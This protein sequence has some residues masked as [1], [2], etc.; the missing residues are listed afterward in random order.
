MTAFGW[1]DWLFAAVITAR[2][3]AGDD[4]AEESSTKWLE[5]STNRLI[6]YSKGAY[7]SDLGPKD[8]LLARRAFGLYN[9]RLVQ[10]KQRVDPL[11]V[12][13][14]A[15]F[16]T[17]TSTCGSDPRVQSRGVVDIICS[18]RCSGK[19]RLA[20]IAA[21]TLKRMLL[22]GSSNNFGGN[23]SVVISSISGGTKRLYAKESSHHNTP[24]DGK[25]LIT[26][27][28][29]KEK[30]RRLLSAFYQKKRAQD[31]AYDVTCYV[32]INQDT[33][34]DGQILFIT[35]MR[36]GL[37]YARTL[38]GGRPVV[39]VN[40]ISCKEVKQSRDGWTYDCEIDKL[41]RECDAAPIVS[42]SNG[43]NGIDSSFLWDL[44]DDNGLK[45]TV[46]TADD[47]T[48]DILVPF[49]LKAG[50][51]SIWTYQEGVLRIGTL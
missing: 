29:Y 50:V 49:I 15:C 42:S 8:I 4:K 12:L 1:R 36:D 51:R 43:T 37:D 45:S 32:D 40:V 23:S 25:K 26:N 41:K 27:R 7:G 31:V 46:T 21:K 28:V 18:P 20:E 35:G 24:I 34:N 22:V 5:D 2:W 33:N 9:M 14:C 39:L 16:L 10:A 48:K 3:P 17:T 30:H 11:N 38:A 19:D 6:S 13:G 47:W 44:T